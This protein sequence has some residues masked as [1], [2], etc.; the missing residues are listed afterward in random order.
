MADWISNSFRGGIYDSEDPNR[1]LDQLYGFYS[2]STERIYQDGNLPTELKRALWNIPT[3]LATAIG[4]YQ[5]ALVVTNNQPV[6]VLHLLRDSMQAIVRAGTD[7]STIPSDAPPPSQMDIMGDLLGRYR[8]WST[9]FDVPSIPPVDLMVKVAAPYLRFNSTTWPPV[10]DG[11]RTLDAYDVI[12][13]DRMPP[14]KDLGAML[15]FPLGIGAILVCRDNWFAD[16]DPTG[17]ELELASGLQVAYSRI[18]QELIPAVNGIVV[19]HE[20]RWPEWARDLIPEVE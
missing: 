19:H 4:T 9:E 3:S 5:G 8:N 6:A 7:W 13:D 10:E 16:W 14:V 11:I 15:R 18:R 1:T 2:A 20:G 12:D 17:D